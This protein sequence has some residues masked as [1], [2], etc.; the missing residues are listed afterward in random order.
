MEVLKRKSGNRYREMIWIN[1]RPIKSPVFCRKSDCVKWLADQRSK[2]IEHILHGDSQRLREK[3]SFGS[4]A[5][6]WMTG[7][8]AIGLSTSTILNYE[9]Y[10]RNHIFPVFCAK[11][12]KAIDK[13]DIDLFQLDLLRDHNAKGTNLIMSVFRSILNEAHREG[14]IFRNPIQG[15]KKISEDILIEAYWTRSEIDQFLRA[16]VND[17]LY[18]LFLV[19]LNTGMRKGELAGLKW[20]RVD[21]ALNQITITR[22]RDKESLKERTK[23]KLKRIVPMNSLVN[24][25]LLHL[26]Y[27]RRTSEYVF[28]CTD[29]SPLK[30][31]HLYRDFS[32]AQKNAKVDK[33]IRFHDLRHTFASQF[34]MNGGSI[35]DLQKI[36]G[37][38]DIKMTMRYA[39]FSREHLQKAIEGFE[40]GQIG[41]SS[42]ILTMDRNKLLRNEPRVSCLH[43]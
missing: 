38:T 4:F 13:N 27:A 34:V 36:L 2:K 17:P 10:L 16:N 32:K 9:S 14:Y 8:K 43:G 20:D 12:I 6:R 22:T 24:A 11:E 35:F 29:N 1:G 28:V 30:V 25:T 26:F 5:E 39:H 15:I 7:K 40:L 31:H 37:H 19:A 3:I 42:H 23:T 21:F 41:E 33:K 18:Y